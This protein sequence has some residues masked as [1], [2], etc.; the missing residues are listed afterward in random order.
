[1]AFKIVFSRLAENEMEVAIDFYESRRKGLGK[2]F[3]G[4]IKGYLKII[5]ANPKLFAIKKEPCFREIA[6]KKF[7]FVIIYEVFKNEIIVYSIFHTSR[8]PSKKP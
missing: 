1:M 6:L 8:N 5:E 3:F 7:P 2:Y 4:Y